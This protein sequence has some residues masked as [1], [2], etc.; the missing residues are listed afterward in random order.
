[1]KIRLE[2]KNFVSNLITKLFY[3]EY[4]KLNR[5]VIIL[6]FIKLIKKPII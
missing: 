2:N 3:D 5:N 6:Q 4:D 1:L